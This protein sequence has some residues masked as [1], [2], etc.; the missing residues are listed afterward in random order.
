MCSSCS[1]AIRCKL[2]I[3][4]GAIDMAKHSSYAVSNT[5]G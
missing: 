2:V 1:V 3:I 5:P 4:L